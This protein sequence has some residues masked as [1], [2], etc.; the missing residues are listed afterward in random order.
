MRKQIEELRDQLID[1]T[2]ALMQDCKNLIR[3]WEAFQFP[4]V[5]FA[6]ERSQLR[7]G[8]EVYE[9]NQERIWMNREMIDRLDDI[10]KGG[11]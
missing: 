7:N 3:G 2:Y 10:L 1:E 5:K 8:M 11:E 9:R 4:K 6:K